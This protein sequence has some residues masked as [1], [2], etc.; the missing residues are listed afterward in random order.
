MSSNRQRLLPALAAITTSAALCSASSAAAENYGRLL[1][2]DSAAPTTSF[3]TAFSHVRPARS[4]LLV[5]TEPN[6]E[7][8][9]FKWSVHCVGSKP[10][11]SGGAFGRARVA[12]GHWVKRIQPRWI[13]HPVSCSGR[14]EGAAA[15]SPVLVRVFVD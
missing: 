13:K 9:D 3:A 10:K 6:T 2:R 5:V 14:I 11:E 8:L 15:A 4:F 7:P 12:S 1:V